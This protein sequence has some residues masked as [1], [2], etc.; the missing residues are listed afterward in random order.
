M[1]KKDISQSPRECPEKALQ[2]CGVFLFRTP[3]D[4]SLTLSRGEGRFCV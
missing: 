2:R 4:L 1:W 3:P